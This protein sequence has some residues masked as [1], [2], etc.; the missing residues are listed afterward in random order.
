[1]PFADNFHD[2]GCGGSCVD[3]DLFQPT[4]LLHGPAAPGATSGRIFC[5]CGSGDFPAKNEACISTVRAS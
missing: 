5:H 2:A 1:M 3:S 4:V